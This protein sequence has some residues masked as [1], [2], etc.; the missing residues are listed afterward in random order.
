MKILTLNSIAPAG[1]QVFNGG[2]T[3]G[4][5]ITDPGGIIVRSAKVNTDNYPNLLAV[6]RAGAGYNN[7]TVDRATATGVCVFNAPGANANAVAELV[8]AVLGAD[9]RQ[10]MPAIAF[11]RTLADLDDSEIMKLVEAEKSRFLGSELA[12]K[13]LSVIGLGQIGVLVA[14][15]GLQKGMRVVAFDSA[16]T[17]PNAHRLHRDVRVVRTI[18][19]VLQVAD[20]LSVHVPLKEETRGM[21]GERELQI[22]RPG[23]TLLN[24][25]REGI[26]DDHAV[27]AALDAGRIGRYITDFPTHDL[28][29]HPKV[30]CTPHLGASTAESEENCAIMAARE[31]R[32]FIETGAVVNSVNFPTVDVPVRPGTTSRITFVNK[33]VPGM[34]A[35]VTGVLADAGINIPNVLGDSNGNVGYY[36]IDVVEQEVPLSVIERLRAIEN[37]IRVRVIPMNG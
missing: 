1:L 19:E 30:V 2:Y 9:A 13:T 4:A 21:I 35:A 36:V 7:I 5:D 26:Y 8:F 24:Y 23:A 16:L 17:V 10:I 3:I 25:A 18:D 34:I 6:A 12:G 15:L 22:I 20:V 33:D 27:L 29:G 37:V 14:N 11:A 28:L 31:L 32:G